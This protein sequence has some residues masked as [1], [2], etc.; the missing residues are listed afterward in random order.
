MFT[1]IS[2][3]KYCI[4][5]GLLVII[6]Y[7]F[8]GF[9]FYYQELKQFLSGK[10]NIKFSTLKN[11]KIEQSCLVTNDTANSKSSLSASFSESLGTLE[12]ADELSNILLNAITESSER[13]LSKDEFRYYLQ[14]IL[15]DFPLVKDSTFRTMIN[16]V[17]VSECEKHPQ[18]IL[19]YAEVDGLWDETI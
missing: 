2:W 6:W 14:L 1:N 13:N 7:V 15:K 16:E 10:Q 5:I 12:D 4:A 3:S 18:M 11:K 8:L 9:R 17:M 19:T